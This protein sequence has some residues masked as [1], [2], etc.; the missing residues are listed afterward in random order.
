ME[1]GALALYAVELT[2]RA[3]DSLRSVRLDAV[4]THAREIMEASPVEYVRNPKL[5]GCVFDPGDTSG[6]VSCADTGFF[7]DHGEPL[8]AL[9]R[10]R[11]RMEWP[12]GALPDGHE[13]LVILEAGRRPRIKAAGYN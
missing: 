13:F 12:L 10:A 5:R 8:E 6:V 1:V 4:R 2:L 7:V 3:L 9:A 11:E